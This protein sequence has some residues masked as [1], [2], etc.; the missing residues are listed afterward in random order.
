MDYS[1]HLRAEKEDQKK[2]LD[3]SSHSWLHSGLQRDTRK[4]NWIS[5]WEDD[6]PR[7]SPKEELNQ[8]LRGWST[9]TIS[10][11]VSAEAPEI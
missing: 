10:I 8:Y 6:Q 2:P 7:Q 5:I 3:L 1:S 11:A 9:K 4:K